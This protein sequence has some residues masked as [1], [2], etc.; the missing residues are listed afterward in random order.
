MSDAWWAALG[1]DRARLLARLRAVLSEHTGLKFPPERWS[2]VERAAERT[3]R[4]QGFADAR[5]WL[6][7]FLAAQPTLAHLEPLI[8]HLTV[9][10]T[11]FFRD[12]ALFRALREVLLPGLIEQRRDSSRCLR[13]WSAGCST[14]EEPYSLAIALQRILP[15]WPQWH[16]SLLA[17]DINPQSLAKARAG[18][19]DTW[20]FRGGLPQPRDPAFER[21]GP[22]AFAVAPQV[23]SMVRFVQL[24]L[25]DTSYPDAGFDS[26]DFIFCRNVLMYL[27]LPRARAVLARLCAALVEGGWLILSAVESS[28]VDLPQMQAVRLDDLILFRKQSVAVPMPPPVPVAQ[29]APVLAA[30]PAPAVV[31]TVSRKAP[32]RVVAPVAALPAASGG[33][34]LI[35]RARASADSGRL[36]EAANHC[37]AAIATDKLNPDW[38][39]LHASI[40]LEQGA[41]G[42][43]ETALKRTLY[44]DAERVQTHVRLANLLWAQP[45]RRAEGLRHFRTALELLSACDE[46]DPV[47]D[48]D[49]M[50]AAQVRTIIQTAIAHD[51]A[52]TY[53][54]SA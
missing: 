10:E 41:R 52:G 46:Q 11:Y 8:V 48:T 18:R 7:W 25:A 36:E 17:S 54:R 43:A 5:G 1:D 35:A 32:P 39:D 50:T 6:E 23:R 21:L 33:P 2:N 49:G 42:A 24:N 13:F 45:H 20:S 29:L 37:E 31:A 14:G 51:V 30:R 15:D 3:G 19:Y 38:T 22:T 12:P 4:D 16:I 53:G 34:A 44:L 47:A 28:L 9:G 27:D 40:L 26:F